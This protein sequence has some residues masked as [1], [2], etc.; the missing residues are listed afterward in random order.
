MDKTLYWIDDDI[1]NIIYLTNH[2]FPVLWGL[3]S[4][5]HIITNVISFGDDLKKGLDSEVLTDKRERNIIHRLTEI[6]KKKCDEVEQANYVH[7]LFE[8]KKYITNNIFRLFA[9]IP[10]EIT[11]GENKDKQNEINDLSKRVMDFW[12]KPENLSNNEE[13]KKNQSDIDRLIAE[14]AIPEDAFVAIDLVLLFK[15]D[16]R[17]KTGNRILSMEL[18][19]RFSLKRPGRCFIYSRYISDL[20]LENA[21]KK[22]YQE[23]YDSATEVRLY[24]RKDFNAKEPNGIRLVDKIRNEILKGE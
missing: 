18:Y 17:V 20:N 5:D 2:V 1:S 11:Q 10:T 16:E 21:W 8:E 12:K 9:K 13:Y 23:N 14:F 24:R 4:S 19:H 3:D 6:F 15:D 22:T 7:H